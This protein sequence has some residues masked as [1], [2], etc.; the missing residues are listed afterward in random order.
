MATTFPL[1]IGNGS[2][3]AVGMPR[4]RWDHQWVFDCAPMRTEGWSPHQQL[5]AAPRE[6][7]GKPSSAAPVQD[8]ARKGKIQTSGS[9]A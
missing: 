6:I 2:A 3:S 9:H 7:R 5:G 1:Q 4:A 8:R